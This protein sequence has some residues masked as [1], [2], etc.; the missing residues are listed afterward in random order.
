MVKY[1][2]G[3]VD[4]QCICLGRSH[5]RSVPAR[6]IAVGAGRVEIWL[7]QHQVGRKQAEASIS[8]G[9]SRTLDNDNP[10]V[11]GDVCNGPGEP[12][13]K[14]NSHCRLLCISQAE[15]N[16]QV[17]L[18]MPSRS[19][20]D[21]SMLLK[22]LSVLDYRNVDRCPN[23][24]SSVCRDYPNYEEVVISAVVTKEKFGTKVP[25]GYH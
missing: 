14:L 7:A 2:S 3:D 1:H 13:G 17:T 19:R 18:R 21:L 22:G 12:T 25:R 24:I 20:R 6:G 5:R 9:K 16:G 15:F 23:R 4:T 10:G 11:C 8:L